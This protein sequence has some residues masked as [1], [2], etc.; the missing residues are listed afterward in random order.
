MSDTFVKVPACY[1]KLLELRKSKTAEFKSLKYLKETTKLRYYQV[2]GALHMMFLDRMVLGD[3]AGLGKCVSEDTYI[4]TSKGLVKI[5]S[6]LPSGSVLKEDCFFKLKGKLNILSV[7]G[8]NAADNLFYS[9]PKTGLNIT[10]S[11]GFELTGLK[12]HPIFVPNKETLEYKKLEELKIADYV[13][14][15]RK[16]LFSQESFKIPKVSCASNANIY[17]IPEYIDEDLAEL[18]GFYVSEGTSC[19]EQSFQITQFEVEN[20]KRIRFLLKKIFNYEQKN[21]RVI[22]FNEEIIVNSVQILKVLQ[23]LGVDFLNKSGGQIIP[24]SILQSPKSIIASFLRGYFEGDGGVEKRSGGISCVSKSE[25]LIK[26]IQL[27]LLQFGIVSKRK[28]KNVKVGNTRKPYWRL[29]FFGKDVDLFKKE[30]GFI[31][32]RKNKELEEIC[33][34][35]RNTN[36]DIIPFGGIL[37]KESM[38]DIISHLKN[39]PDQKG[40]SIKG[41]GW[42]GLV[43][44]NYKRKLEAYLF[45]GCKLTYSGLK[46]FIDTVEKVKLTSIVSNMPLLKDIYEKNI[47]FDKIESIVEKKAIFYDFHVPQ[48]HNFTGNGFINHNTVQTIAA[49]AWC[50]EQTPDLKI[51]IVA[52]KSA[53]YQWADEFLK[54]SQGIAVKV[55]DNDLGTMKGLEARKFQYNTFKEHVMI[56]GYSQVRSDYEYIK[57]ALGTN[58][59]VVFD[60]VQAIKGRKTETNFSCGEVARGAKRVYGLS[61]TVIKNGLEEVWGIYSVIVPGLFGNIT[62]FNKNYT[63]TKLLKLKIKGVDRCIPQLDITKGNGGYKNL[64]QFKQVIDPYILVR[65]KEEVAS[66]LP[67]LI[68]R[69][70]VI[71]MSPEQKE[72]YKQALNGI[73]YEEKVKREYFEISDKVRAGYNDDKILKRYG[74]LKEKYE[75][76]LTDEG[77]KRGKLAALTYC[78][79][80]SNGPSLIGEQGESS[81]ELEFERLISDELT[82]EKIIVFTRFKKGITNMEIICDRKHIGHTKITGDVD[83][84][85]ERDQA[86]KKFMEDPSCRIMFITNAG[87]ASLNLQAASVIIFYDTPWSYGDL[88]QIIGRAQRIGS[89]QE[90]VLLLHLCNKNSIDMRVMKR[91][92]DKK[93]LSDEVLG[94]TSKGALDF[95][96]NENTVIDSLFEDILEDAELLKEA[97]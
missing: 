74:E 18:M 60:E 90:H 2:I 5:G 43:G 78:Q 55:I 30:I 50:L 24:F 26:Q 97:A 44:Y 81:K 10:T 7:E 48:T 36:L 16:G 67:K 47:F 3:A 76:F 20:H 54:F 29:Y 77:K 82:Q 31:S 65:K 19:R 14:I 32:D 95:T 40:F 88:V 80:I 83:T 22:N 45:Y 25:E 4:P 89:I 85:W 73:I 61:A 64:L 23:S 66:E 84:A 38:K 1:P 34:I 15:N 35:P 94:D 69:Q 63:Y 53:L 8:L 11:K 39:Q 59:M 21:D 62:S 68:S 72:L 33:N 41:S 6:L 9:G 27:I 46:E 57:P 93:E 75:L 91:V 42:K 51:L 13:C 17:K 79:M 37:L 56:L 87:S 96:I 28:I 70:V 49:Y 86:K 58:Y 12:H 92:A 71:E 52:P